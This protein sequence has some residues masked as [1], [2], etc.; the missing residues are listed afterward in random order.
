MM[1]AAQAFFDDIE[2][3][4]RKVVVARALAAGATRDQADHFADTV[5]CGITHVQL[6]RLEELDASDLQFAMARPPNEQIYT[7]EIHMTELRRY[8]AGLCGP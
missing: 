5:L 3:A 8:F 6:P 7:D 1:K 2:R 4:M